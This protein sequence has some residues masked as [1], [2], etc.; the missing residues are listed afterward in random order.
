[1][2]ISRSQVRICG[3][4]IMNDD[5]SAADVVYAKLHDE[6]TARDLSLAVDDGIV[7]NASTDSRPPRCSGTAAGDALNRLWRA[8]GSALSCVGGFRADEQKT[9]TAGRLKVGACDRSYVSQNP[10]VL[11]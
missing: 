9:D 2:C 3:L 7:D 5:P 1:M 4:E 6:G 10:T 8:A 11:N